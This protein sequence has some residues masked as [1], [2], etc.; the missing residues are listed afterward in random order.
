MQGIDEEFALLKIVRAYLCESR[1][2]GVEIEKNSTVNSKVEETLTDL[3]AF[4][5]NLVAMP[6]TA[7]RLYA[8]NA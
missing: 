8:Y 3:R 5:L 1:L 2:G 4:A 7:N 6:S